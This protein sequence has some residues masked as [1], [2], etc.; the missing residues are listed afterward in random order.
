MLNRHDFLEWLERRVF[1]LDGAMGTML[2]E[3]GMSPGDPP[4]LL[5]L[6]HPQWVKEVHMT[7][8]GLGVDIVTSNTFGANKIKLAHYGYGERVEEINTIAINL[9]R[10]VAQDKALIAASIGP[11][12]RF[13]EPIGDLSFDAAREVFQEQIAA[14]IKAGAQLILIETFSDIKEAKAAII[15]AR[16]LSPT[17]PII[18]TLTFQ[19]DLRTLL[20]TGPEEACIILEALDIDLIGANCGLGPEQI[21]EVFRRMKG[22]SRKKLVFQPNAGMPVVRDG[23]T[24][25]PASPQSMA[26]YASRLVKEGTNIIGCC[27]GC[28]SAHVEAVRKAVRE[29][30][31]QCR[32]ITPTTAVASRTRWIGLGKGHMPV[33]VGERINPTGKDQLIGELREGRLSWVKKAAQDQVRYGAQILDINLGL[34]GIDEAGLM[35]KAV[36]EIQR[37]VD[38]PL[39]ID[40]SRVEVLERGL[41]EVAGKPIINSVNGKEESLHRVLP[42]AKKYGAAVVGLTLDERGIPESPKERLAIARRIL[43]AAALHG[44][45][46]Q[47]ILID[48]LILS[49]SSNPNYAQETLTTLRLIKEELPVATVLGISNVSYG[50]PQRKI[51]NASFLAMALAAGL[52][53]A[54]INPMDPLIYQV[55]YA[56]ALLSGRDHQAQRYLSICQSALHLAS[57]EDVPLRRPPGR[58]IR[59]IGE[60]WI[61]RMYE[62]VINGDTEGL[63]G[64]LEQALSEEGLPRDLL[65]DRLIKTLDLVGQAFNN[66]EL[67]FPQLI[68]AAQTV[69]KAFEY[70]K[71]RGPQQGDRRS[72]GR[73]L[74]ATVYG[75]IHDIGKNI[76]RLILETHGFEVIDLGRNVP[77]RDIVSAVQRYRPHIVGLSALMTSTMQ[78][79]GRVIQAFKEAGL[80]CAVMVGGAV[81]TPDFARQI[82]ADMYA[83]DAIE[84]ACL[85]RGYLGDGGQKDRG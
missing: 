48:C 37:L 76:V 75:D 8:V 61:D 79:M 18:C 43:E 69:Q 62:Q 9:A 21:Y 24:S 53:A 19:E 59:E 52:D 63:V 28:S 38:V 25:F 70:L 81:V 33:I 64:L 51:L 82:G 47:D 11:T 20:G 85:A 55:F 10:E 60:A 7:Y 78:E 45:P 22:M 46:Q 73:V 40:T 29:V 5:N 58:I 31:P 13:I 2:Q 16:E 77:T 4:E 68:L 71:E 41:R 44:I 80:D 66:N 36:L 35:A 49:V 56:G 17:L 1:V 15:A 72:L 3:K 34:P 84:A 30:S 54:I 39:M 57:T 26:D 83:K 12:G 50:L 32:S 14:C 65:D 74:L 67:F 23:R 6:S 42:L 27:C